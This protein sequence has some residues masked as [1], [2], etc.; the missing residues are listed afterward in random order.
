MSQIF[1]DCDGVLA[2][3]DRAAEQLFQQNSRQA[4]AAL[5]TKIFWSRISGCGSFYGDLP[6]LPDAMRLYQSIAHL[7][8]IILTGCP[9]GGWAEPQK[10]EWAA[11]HFPGVEIITCRS[12]DKSR[13]LRSPGDILVDDYLK[14]QNLWEEAGGIFVHH[15]TADLSIQHL[16][17]LGLPVRQYAI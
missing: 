10:V 14:Y 3:F 16:A 11:R 8:P 5:G 15:Q 13:F 7:H 17:R 6:L 9:A 4:E 2:D 12:R 1:L